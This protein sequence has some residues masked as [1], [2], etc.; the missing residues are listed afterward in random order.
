LI[1]NKEKLLELGGVHQ[2]KIKKWQHKAEEAKEQG[3][4]P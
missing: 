3:M 1:Y 2:D 4:A